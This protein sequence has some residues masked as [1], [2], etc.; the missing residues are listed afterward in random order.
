MQSKASVNDEASDI[1]IN[2]ISTGNL[3][4]SRYYVENLKKVKPADIRRVIDKYFNKNNMT[5]VM[6]LPETAKNK[7]NLK[8]KHFKVNNSL[9]QYKLDN[10]IKLIMYE[11]KNT[12]L[13][14]VNV[15]MKGGVLF[16]ENDKKGIT[17]FLSKMLLAG[18]KKY[19]KKN[20]I[21]LFENNGGTISTFAGNNSFGIRTLF[22]KD[23]TE[24]LLPV[25]KDILKNSIF[26]EK[27]IEK[28]RKEIISE[29][30]SVSEK[31]FGIAKI[32]LFNK[33]F[34]NTP[35]ENIN[36]GSVK[37]IKNITRK[38]IVRY[39]R[40]FFT[41]D[42]VVVS[43]AG[44]MDYNIIKSV[45]G[46]NIK[47]SSHKLKFNRNIQLP[48]KKSITF[49][50]NTDKEQSLLLVSYYGPNVTS[51]DR[52]TEEMLWYVLNGQGSRLFVNLR[53]KR[54]LAYYVGMFPFYGLKAGLMNFYIGTVKN[55]I[56]IAHKGMLKEI[57]KL[58]KS[59][60]TKQELE[61]AKRE[62]LSDKIKEFEGVNNIAFNIGL[63]YL[64]GYKD[65]T[66]NSYKRRINSISVAEVNKFIEKYFKYKPWF[67]LFILGL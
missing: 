30:E 14:S 17:Y 57:K 5:I 50:T 24:R 67:N 8:D 36:I 3:D 29:I 38:D 6:L 65:I 46:N 34:Y 35:Y 64:Y 22:L 49:K 25:I 60:I 62:A 32:K 40:K 47:I 43:V 31:L 21:E 28:T 13:V 27:E 15:L 39:Y 33:M 16:E 59:G 54:E 63:N 9:K 51:E 7:N 58:I 53:E 23:D 61:S 19:S 1:G 12:E 66:I 48:V 56:D 42:N 26:P 11:D 45:F 44:N 41:K 20:L 4:F 2:W 52:Y 10:G 55:K 18:T 37:S